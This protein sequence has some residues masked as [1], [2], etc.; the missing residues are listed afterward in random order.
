MRNN[1]FMPISYRSIRVLMFLSVT[2]MALLSSMNTNGQACGPYTLIYKGS[3]QI[4]SGQSVMLKFP[5]SFHFHSK[6][7]KPFYFPSVQ[8]RETH[9][10]FSF[11]SHLTDPFLPL[12]RLIDLYQSKHDFIPLEISF[13]S[14]HGRSIIELIK[15]PIE[16]VVM[17]GTDGEDQPTRIILD[18]GEI[19]VP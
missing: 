7:K 19:E 6:H 10:E 4:P 15:I 2:I 1:Q 5:S 16:Q 17:S 3:I 14:P 12:E 11:Q 13:L 18:F 8:L 9:F